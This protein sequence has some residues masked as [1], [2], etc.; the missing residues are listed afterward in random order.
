[1]AEGEHA[2]RDHRIVS[3]GAWLVV[4]VQCDRKV[5]RIDADLLTTFTGL[6]RVVRFVGRRIGHAGDAPCD[7]AA[8][9]FFMSMD[10][11]ANRLWRGRL[12]FTLS[13]SGGLL[14]LF[15]LV[16]RA[17]AAKGIFWEAWSSSGTFFATYFNHSNAG[18]F[19]NL[20]LP[21]VAGQTFLA[22]RN[23]KGHLQRASWCFLLLVSITAVFV[24]T[25]RASMVIGVVLMI[26]LAVGGI[27]TLPRRSNVP[28]SLR[29]LPTAAVV[30]ACAITL[31]LSFGIQPSLARWNQTMNSLFASKTGRSGMAD[32]PSIGFAGS[33]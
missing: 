17:T 6:A 8:G 4:S 27:A 1:M 32:S 28:L 18:A 31:I 25:S 24:N 20:T 9:V 10:L 33:H 2:R 23:E 19:I 14:L 22:F 12:F 3:S 5:R 13:L 7:G 29:V 11:A 21:L 15:G 16:E 26:A 30:V